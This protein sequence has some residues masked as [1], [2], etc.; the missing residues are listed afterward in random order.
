M[1]GRRS[2][3]PRLAAA[4]LIGVAL[5][6]TFAE[7]GAA[8]QAGPASGAADQRLVAIGDIH[9]DLE[10]FDGILRKAGL[11]DTA[12]RW[13][14][15]R[16]TLV[17]TGDYTDRGPRVRG[18]FDRLMA[19]EREARR[20]G[21]RV[22]VLLG[23]HETMNL[24]SEMRD[25]SPDT[26]AEFA[27]TR[28]ERRRSAAYDAT[29]RLLTRQAARLKDGPPPDLP[30]REAWMTAYPLGLIEY[31]EA[32]SPS[33]RYGRWLRQRR[34]VTRVGGT[35]FLHAGLDPEVVDLD[36]EGI[37][38]RVRAELA[39]FDRARDVLVAREVVLK[40]FTLDELV[41][42]VGRE[43]RQLN[44][45]QQAGGVDPRLADGP[46][47]DALRTFGALNTWWIFQE[48]GPL[49]FRGFA[50]WTPDEGAPRLARLREI[51]GA[52]R[53]VVG[54]T[55]MRDHRITSRFDGQIWLIDTGM[56]ARVYKGRA[57]ALEL[58]GDAV[59]TLYAD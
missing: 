41:A 19:L 12:G 17:Q 3:A 14:G 6:W 20:A 34:V 59:S 26:F 27:D 30:V 7:R 22:E 10:A 33:G 49:W 37:N 24:T 32:L 18:V 25:V 55:V 36:V 51:H 4:T 57:S 44:V 15:R 29:V 40:T 53:F 54:H 52:D 58:R 39:E 50:T 13:T 31:I 21:G 43:V 48:R 46:L 45:I 35:V 38:A 11:I 16:A 5:I 1:T 2:L 8:G 9:G 28:S 56:L 47:L 42:A 23:N